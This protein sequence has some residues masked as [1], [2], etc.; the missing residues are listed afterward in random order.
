MCCSGAVSASTAAQT[1]SDGARSFKFVL[2]QLM[3]KYPESLWIVH[4]LFNVLYYVD[5]QINMLA[6][7]WSGVHR[8]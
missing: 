7:H 1:H 6:K 5:C 8:R 4:K 3:R 2:L